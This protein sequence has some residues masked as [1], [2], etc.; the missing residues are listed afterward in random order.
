MKKI[1]LVDTDVV[2]DFLRGYN[3]A[4]IYLKKHLHEIALSSIAVAELFAGVKDDEK[5]KLDEFISLFPVFPITIEIAKAG[6]MLKRDYHRSHGVGLA[7]ALMAA[8]ALVHNAELKTL[9][10]KH[11]PMF[12]KL[13]PPYKKI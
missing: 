2:V 7:D 5:E 11:Y 6:G 13:I 10:T 4:V 3:K 8:T 1:I 9:N 12:K